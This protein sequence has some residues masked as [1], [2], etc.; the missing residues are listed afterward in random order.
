MYAESNSILGA[1]V[2]EHNKYASYEFHEEL[3]HRGI[4]ALSE[5]SIKHLYGEMTLFKP[6]DFAIEKIDENTV[7]KILEKTGYDAFVSRIIEERFLREKLSG[8]FGYIR[9][10][11]Q[12]R[13]LAM[14][15]I[16]EGNINVLLTALSV[17]CF[18]EGPFTYEISKEEVAEKL[19]KIGLLDYVKY[20]VW[21]SS[22][23]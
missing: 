18:D 20:M 14:K 5:G 10:E 3:V 19:E 7:R 15:A 12:L 2:R 16:N 4:K 9:V 6:D 11:E 17:P 21:L 1:Y 13:L 22:H 8:K 23:K